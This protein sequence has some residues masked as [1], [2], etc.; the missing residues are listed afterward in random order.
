MVKEYATALILNVLFKIQQKAKTICIAKYIDLH[1]TFHHLTL[2]NLLTHRNHV[3]NI[4]INRPFLKLAKWFEMH[5]V[6]L[7]KTHVTHFLSNLICLH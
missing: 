7:K 1:N 4:L 5:Y 3:I 6:K 2:V